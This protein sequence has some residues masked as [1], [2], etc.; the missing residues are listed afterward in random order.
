MM[1]VQAGPA[2]GMRMLVWSV[3]G[4]LLLLWSLLAW[5][6]HALVGA[7]GDALVAGSGMLPG[8]LLPVDPA[9]VGWLAG[10]LDGLA[11]FG[12]VLVWVLWA[13]VAVP[14]LGLGLL[15]HGFAPALGTLWQARRGRAAATGAPWAN[16]PDLPP[17]PPFATGGAPSRGAV[18]DVRPERVSQE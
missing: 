15:G 11:G 9:Q 4:V 3:V 13:I 14:L 7:G 12:Q 10:V 18:Y 17:P 8:E 16:D 1:A 6:A 5:G 2:R